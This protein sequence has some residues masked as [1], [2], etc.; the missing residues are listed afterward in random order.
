M[1]TYPELQVKPVHETVPGELVV[2]D[3]SGRRRVPAICAPFHQSQDGDLSFVLIYLANDIDGIHGPFYEFTDERLLSLGTD[4]AV[5]VDPV[6]PPV[7]APYRGA[8]RLLINGGDR[9]LCVPDRNNRF[10]LALNL[11][12]G[13]TQDVPQIFRAVECFHWELR[14]KRDGVIDFDQPA[15]F[16]WDTAAVAATQSQVSQR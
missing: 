14:L 13:K 2:V 12:V 5:V 3:F 6:S 16:T 10:W 11:E 8:P 9:L 15:L 7:P 1:R 4:Y